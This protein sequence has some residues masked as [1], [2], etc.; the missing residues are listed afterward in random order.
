METNLVAGC[1]QLAVAHLLKRRQRLG[2][3]GVGVTRRLD[4]GVGVH[5]QPLL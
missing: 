2:E 3:Q 5:D 4:L 1:Q